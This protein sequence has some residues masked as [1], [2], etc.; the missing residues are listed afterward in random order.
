[1]AEGSEWET[2]H[3]EFVTVGD[4]S[5]EQ[6]NKIRQLPAYLLLN[7]L[8]RKRGFFNQIVGKQSNGDLARMAHGAETLAKNIQQKQHGFCEQTKERTGSAI[9][10]CC[11]FVK[12]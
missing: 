4:S 7:K 5:V 2:R 1:V 6:I 12:E 11:E 8:L 3:D 9:S 10:L